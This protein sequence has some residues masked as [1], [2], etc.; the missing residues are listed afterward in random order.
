MVDT[1]V[2]MNKLPIHRNLNTSFV[3]M[4][5]LVRHLRNLGFIG[6]IQLELSSYEAEI[7]FANDGSIRAREQDHIADRLSFGDD[8]L[9]RIMIRSKEPGGLVHVYEGLGSEKKSEGIFVD[10]A[11]ADGARRMAAGLIG[12]TSPRKFEPMRTSTT[13]AAVTEAPI[14]KPDERLDVPTTENWTELLALISE[15]MQ[16]VD[17]SLAKGNVNFAKL[18]RN[19]CGFVSLEHPFLDPDSDVFAYADGY[20]SVRQRLSAR[21]LISGITSALARIMQRLGEDPYFGNVCHQTMHRIRVLANRRK[22]Q[23]QTFGLGLELQRITGI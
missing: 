9:Q 1:L 12:G 3:S 10:Q 21:D 23:F 7:E 17:A 15:L 2:L 5:G 19:A 8:A 14:P 22:L 16:T 11:I 18:F 13:A 20:I 4:S 6:S